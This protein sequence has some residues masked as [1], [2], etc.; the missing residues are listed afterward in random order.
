M[1]G[2]GVAGGEKLVRGEARDVPGGIGGAASV[3]DDAHAE[4]GSDAGHGASD[5]AEADDAE[6]LAGEF[7]DGMVEPGEDGRGGPPIRPTRGQT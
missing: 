6:G 2:D 7:G 1:Q 4:G 5:R 3:G